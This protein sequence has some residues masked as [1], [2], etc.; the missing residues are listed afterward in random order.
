MKPTVLYFSL[1]IVLALLVSCE[2]Q[3]GSPT[4]K[5]GIVTDYDILVESLQD[6]GATVEPIGTVNQPFFTPQGQVIAIDG[7]DVQFFEYDT[8]ADADTEA[9]L[10]SPD[11]SSVGTSMM[12]WIATP[13]FYKS[14]TLI[15]LYVGDLSDTITILE[16]ALGP[17][18]AGG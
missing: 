2:S 4:S 8:V 11:G 10:V 1:L 7:Q 16:G 9:D 18:F 5:E 6:A 17:Q 15:V 13:H 12:T 14:G 3:E